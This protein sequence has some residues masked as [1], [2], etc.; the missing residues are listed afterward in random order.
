MHAVRDGDA[1]ETTALVAET[2]II[3]LQT[4]LW[5]VLAVV[6]S[7]GVPAINE[8]ILKD[9]EVAFGLYV[10]AVAYTLGILFDRLAAFVLRPLENRLWRFLRRSR[11]SLI[12]ASPG[13]LLPE[14]DEI[15]MRLRDA[16]GE[17]ANEADD[18][19]R[20]LRI[21]RATVI[22]L[23]ITVVLLFASLLFGGQ[24]VIS[25]EFS[26][27]LSIFCVLFLVLALLA[28]G[29][30][31]LQYYRRLVTAYRVA[32]RTHQEGLPVTTA[33]EKS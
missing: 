25:A 6:I 20:P 8:R 18:L 29:A 28:Y 16:H 27:R 12:R 19:R 22:N 13:E 4:T 33:A 9:W 32:Y 30:L 31:E 24:P 26:E 2:L 15:R 11:P 7:S 3:G 23:F 21:T 10:V 1:I 14:V 17:I 5:V